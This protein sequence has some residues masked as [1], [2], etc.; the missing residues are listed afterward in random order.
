[1]ACICSPSGHKAWHRSESGLAQG[2]K[3]LHLIYLLHS[4]SPQ[5]LHTPSGFLRTRSR[6]SKIKT[7]D[8]PDQGR[9][10]A[11]VIPLVQASFQRQQRVQDCSECAESLVTGH[12]Q[13]QVTRVDCKATVTPGH[14]AAPGKLA[15]ACIK[16]TV[17]GCAERT[18]DSME[19]KE[20]QR[21]G[22]GASTAPC[23]AL[24]AV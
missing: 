7:Q 15:G 2:E 4:Q 1:M 3:S 16:S 19:C 23:C 8:Q 11:Q 5:R 20:Q 18:C 6:V 9:E 14:K 17:H 24:H 22:N 12:R 13:R 10:S 21:S